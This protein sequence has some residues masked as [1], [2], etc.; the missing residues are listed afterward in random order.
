VRLMNEKRMS[1][2]TLGQ[3]ILYLRKKRGKSQS[4]I[5]ATA[6]ISAAMLSQVEKDK[7]SPSVEVL[8]AL[9]DALE[10]NPA[11]LFTTEEVHVFDMARLRARYKKAEDLDDTLYRALSEVARYA[12][13][14][15]LG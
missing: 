6:G 10:I 8:G 12:K 13:K 3:R 9:A 14:L 1:K 4:D 15:G 11:I 2:Y 7:K 5:A